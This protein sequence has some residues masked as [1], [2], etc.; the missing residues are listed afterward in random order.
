MPANTHSMRRPVCSP[1]L[2]P[3]TNEP[4]N[5][6]IYEHSTYLAQPL[7]SPGSPV[8][9]PSVSPFRNASARGKLVVRTV[10]G[11]P[12]R[13]TGSFERRR[14]RVDCGRDPGFS[15]LTTVETISLRMLGFGKVEVTGV[16]IRWC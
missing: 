9:L 4:P 11:S 12:A 3:E 1:V 13:C 16:E 7:W 2:N 14:T 15:P 6:S 8:F 5:V 10:G